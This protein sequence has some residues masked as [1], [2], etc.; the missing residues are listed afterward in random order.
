MPEKEVQQVMSVTDDPVTGNT[1]IIFAVI[2]NKIDLVEKMVKLGGNL[3]KQNKENYSSFHFG[4]NYWLYLQS[5]E[6]YLACMYSS[7]S[8]ISHLLS[9]WHYYSGNSQ[10]RDEEEHDPAHDLSLTQHH[11]VH[12]PGGVQKQSCLHLVSS[13]QDQEA[14]S[15][16]KLLLC[17]WDQT[18]VT[19]VDSC[20]NI[21]LFCAIEAGNTEVVK[22]LLAVDD[23][24][25]VSKH[26]S[27][28]WSK[29]K[30]KL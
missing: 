3:S 7:Y 13:R 20:Q 10:K 9:N 24:D 15:I 6:W 18:C 11:A 28:L 5:N 2:N 30:F 1:P 26:F 19:Q 22:E 8:N 21:P 17:H 29:L 14:A 12:G 25:Q 27:S 16:V 23:N 4:K